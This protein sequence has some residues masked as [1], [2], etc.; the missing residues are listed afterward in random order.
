MA[1]DLKMHHLNQFQDRELL[2]NTLAL[3]VSTELQNILKVKDR[4]T[5][6]V[7]GG[8]TPKPFFSKLSMMDLDWKRVL[9][10]PTDERFVPETSSLSNTGLIR[11]TLLQNYAKKAQFMHFFKP[12]FTIAELA[13]HI[14]EELEA[15]LPLDICI[16]GMGSDMHTASIFPKS[17]RLADALDLKTSEIV[18]PIKA[19]FINEK[20]LTLTARILRE[21]SKIH[22]LLTGPDKKA[23]LDFAL[24]SNDSWNIAPVRSVLFSD[25]QLK[26]HYAN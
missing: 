16:L 13:S 15:Y 12:N 25:N 5:L 19:P 14:S 22:L 11:A 24:K 10:I 17:D 2:M 4:V 23:A 6:A 3:Q 26:I 8:S 9:I 21:A 1:R 18:I 7:P 20:R